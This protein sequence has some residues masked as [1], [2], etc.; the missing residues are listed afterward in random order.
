MNFE[1]EKKAHLKDPVAAEKKLLEAGKFAGE[2]V[3]EDCY[4]LIRRKAEKKIDMK[5]DPIF[6]IRVVGERCWISAKKRTFRGKTEIN[7][8]AEIPA[9]RP[10][11]TIWFF[12]T[13]LGLTPFVRKRKKTRLFKIDDINVEINHVEN[14]GCFLEVEIQKESLDR[15]EEKTI[16]ERIDSIFKLLEISE[17]DVEPKY[18]IEM[19]MEKENG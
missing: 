17:E 4:Y 3:K 15:D 5:N 1:I 2:A 12:E 7:E 13:Y 14:L 19:L 11:E 6:R 18:Y 8:E 10:D 16:L 9:G